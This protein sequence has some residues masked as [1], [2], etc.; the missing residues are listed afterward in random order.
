M[1][2]RQASLLVADEIYYNLHGKAILH[3]IYVGDL[4]ISTN[5]S[6]APQLIF[7]FMAET[8]ITDPFRT[9]MAEITLPESSPI[10]YPIPVLLPTTFPPSDR[11]RL[12]ARW[13]I[14]MPTPILRPGK[15]NVKMNHESGEIAVMAPWIV[16]TPSIPQPGKDN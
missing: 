6:S 10:R 13:P 1:T 14:L 5:P 12:F 16:Y 9:L 4:V 3:G 15:I 11:T 8:D 7:F 2:A